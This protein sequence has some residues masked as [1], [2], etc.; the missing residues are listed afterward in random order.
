MPVKML[1]CQMTRKVKTFTYFQ[2]EKA[3]EELAS[4]VNK[5]PAQNA[6]PNAKQK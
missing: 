2:R 4:V 5:K 1:T 6:Q 3:V